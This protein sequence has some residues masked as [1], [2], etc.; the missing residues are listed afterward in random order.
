MQGDGEA[1][2]VKNTGKTWKSI[3]NPAIATFASIAKPSI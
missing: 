3:A 1:E 2:A